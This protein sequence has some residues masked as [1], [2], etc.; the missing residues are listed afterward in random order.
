MR[1]TAQDLFRQATGILLQIEKQAETA[2]KE[3][4]FVDYHNIA[5]C[6]ARDQLRR[7]LIEARLDRAWV[8]YEVAKTYDPESPQYKK[9]LSD[10]AG[11]FGELC[12]RRETPFLVAG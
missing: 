11:G 4:G 8:A 9:Q 1:K 7:Q 3:F 2:L 10:A 5:R 12:T 6:N